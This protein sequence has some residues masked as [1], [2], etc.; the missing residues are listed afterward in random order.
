MTSCDSLPSA[1][2][3]KW[4]AKSWQDGRCGHH[5]TNETLHGEERPQARLRSHA[6]KAGETFVVASIYACEK[7]AEWPLGVVRA[8]FEKALANL[9]KEL[10]QVNVKGED[11]EQ[12]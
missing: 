7:D 9:L 10:K 5:G 12:E 6:I 8:T 11:E 3:A 1:K 2:Q 4:L